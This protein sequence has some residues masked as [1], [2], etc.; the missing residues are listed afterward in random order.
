[1]NNFFTRKIINF[2]TLS[3]YK[4]YTISHNMMSYYL[5]NLIL[6][7]NVNSLYKMSTHNLMTL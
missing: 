3:M 4:F 5:V 7:V 2:N 6:H 1:M